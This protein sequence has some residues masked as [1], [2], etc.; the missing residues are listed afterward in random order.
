MAVKPPWDYKALDGTMN[1]D[2]MGAKSQFNV[3]TGPN[4]RDT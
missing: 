4:T 1:L 3:L 2:V